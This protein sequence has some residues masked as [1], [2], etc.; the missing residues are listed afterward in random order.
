MRNISIVLAIA[1]LFVHNNIVAQSRADRRVVRQLKEDIGYLA[2]DELEG[3]RVGSEGERK[4]AAYIEKRYKD[5]GIGAYKGKYQHEFTY[6][7]GKKIEDATQIKL[8]NDLLRIKEEAFPLAFSGNKKAYGEVIPDVFES[9]NI[10]MIPMYADK[11][12]AADAHFEWEKKAY[13][14][15]SEAEKQG[16]TGVLFYDNY[17]AKF[18]PT[19]NAKTEYESLE[20]PVGFL[21][22]NAFQEYTPKFKDRNEMPVEINVLLK[23]SDLIGHNITAFID[24]KAPYTVILGAHYDHLGFGQD[25]N[26]LH[27]AKDGQVHNGADD[28]AS[29]TAAL[30][31]IAESVK[32]SRLRNYNYLF[33]S[34]SGEEEGLIGSKAIVRDMGFDSNK[35]AYMVNMD[36]VG[37]LNDSTH[38]LTI[39]GIGTSPAWA[40]FTQPKNFKVSVDSSGAGPSDHTS[41]YR[42]GIPV[43]FFFTGLH[44]DYHKPSDDADKINYE[45]EAQVIHY[46]NEVVAKMDKEPKPGFRTTKEAAVGKVRFKVTLGIM[47]DYSFQ[48][49]GVK[50]DGVTDGKPA[51]KAGIQAGD[52]ITQ[53]GSHKVNGMQTYMEALGAFKE[54]DKTEVTIIRGEDE[55]KLPIEFK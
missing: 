41:F 18:P 49:G 12:E 38:A 5:L 33:I 13:E 17:N 3:R 44:T 15:A 31:Q 29:G 26:S 45:G 40:Q 47:P 52:I 35:I 28:N 7:D 11:E 22:F 20:I 19:Y 2:S 1:G 46:I 16:A 34:F 23:R 6:I 37:R 42:A 43:L 4:A 50:V 53:L 54:G 25:G 48:E 8:G 21:N 51:K 55:I 10:W 27:A 24:N 36:M 39:G 32:K 14:R 30:M 9:G